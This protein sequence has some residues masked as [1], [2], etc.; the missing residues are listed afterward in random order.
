MSLAPDVN[1]KRRVLSGLAGAKS[2]AAMEMAMAYLEDP[3]LSREAEYAAVKIAGGIRTD[4]PEL[5]K[6]TLKKIVAQ[7]KNDT[8][9][10][11]AQEVLDEME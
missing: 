5:A 1:E 2:R 9:R 7:T 10:E 3:T 8:L 11:Q 4:S 6:E